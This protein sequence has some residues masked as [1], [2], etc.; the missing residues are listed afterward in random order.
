MSGK[1]LA[2]L[3]NEENKHEVLFSGKGRNFS[4]RERDGRRE[5]WL[6]EGRKVDVE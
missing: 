6:E 1:S 4:I 3:G 2:F 5:V